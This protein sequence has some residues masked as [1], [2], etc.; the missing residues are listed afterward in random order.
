MI[1]GEE[2]ESLRRGRVIIMLW[3]F[4][5]LNFNT[6]SVIVHA[7]TP[8]FLPSLNLILIPESFCRQTMTDSIRQPPETQRGSMQVIKASIPTISCQLLSLMKEFRTLSPAHKFTQYFQN[9]IEWLPNN[10]IALFF[11][12]TTYPAFLSVTQWEC[13]SAHHSR[14][15]CY[16]FSPFLF[17]AKCF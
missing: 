13:F 10:V 16:S 4:Y 1:K 5:W 2:N 12:S 14:E 8:S 11:P 15:R 17:V 6:M 3:G 7:C 9:D